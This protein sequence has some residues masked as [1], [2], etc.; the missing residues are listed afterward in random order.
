MSGGLWAPFT[1]KIFACITC[2]RTCCLVGFKKV[3]WGAWINQFFFERSILQL[4]WLCFNSPGKILSSLNC[5]WPHLSSFCHSDL[6]FRFF[7]SS[8]SQTLV[9]ITQEAIPSVEMGVWQLPP[10]LSNVPWQSSLLLLLAS[11]TPQCRLCSVWLLWGWLL[12]LLLLRETFSS[13]WDLCDVSIGLLVKWWLVH[14][15]KAALPGEV[16]WGCQTISSIFLQE[17]MLLKLQLR[18]L[19]STFLPN[20]LKLKVLDMGSKPS[21]PHYLFELFFCDPVLWVWKCW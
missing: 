12:G 3:S 8:T 20:C 15:L 5:A 21:S 6:W 11:V 1:N 14:L 2:G 13:S 4:V 16:G 9:C 17:M 18:G 10:E 7:S 19:F